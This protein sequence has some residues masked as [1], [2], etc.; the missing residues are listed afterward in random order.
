MGK[1][2]LAEH[3]EV[4]EVSQKVSEDIA[5]A[6]GPAAT[7]EWNAAWDSDEGESS[8]TKV[9]SGT[10]PIVGTKK[11]IEDDEEDAVDDDA[12]GWGDEP[13]ESAEEPQ[14]EEKQAQEPLENIEARNHAV[15]LK[16]NYWL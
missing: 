4:H 1:I 10:T 14:E 16:E 8:D 5:A 15:T 12:W 11:H 7:E 6:T 13:T 2:H 9:G 3:V